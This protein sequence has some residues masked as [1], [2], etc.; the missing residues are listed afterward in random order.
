MNTPPEDVRQD[1]HPDRLRPAPSERFAGAR[2]AFDLHEALRALR[3]D[4]SVAR[5]GHRQ[6]TLF[7][8]PPV[9]QVLFAFDEGGHMPTHMAGGLVTI[10]VLEGTLMVQAEG[11]EHRLQAGSLLVLTPGVP[12]DVRAPAASAMLLTV[13]MERG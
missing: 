7:Q 1:D 10:H 5:N 4:G 12:H 6:M 9:T 2:H 8:R 13:H 3:K 11:V